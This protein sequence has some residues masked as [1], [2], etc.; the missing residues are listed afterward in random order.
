MIAI[1]V[2]LINKNIDFTIMQ[3]PESYRVEVQNELD[4]AI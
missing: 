1:Y 2:N 4:K 3:V